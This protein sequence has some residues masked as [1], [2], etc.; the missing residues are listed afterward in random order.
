M[1]EA[2]EP[3]AIVDLVDT[4]PVTGEHGGDVDLLAVHADASAGGDQDVAVL[5]GVLQLG[6][7]GVWP[8]RGAVELGGASHSKRLMWPFLIEFAEEGIEAVLLLQA[9]VAWR[10]RGL[11]L[12]REVHALVAAVLLR[13]AWLDALDLDGE[14]EPPERELGEVVEA[15]GAGEGQA[16]VASEGGRQAA[17]L[18]Q[19]DKGF[20]DRAFLGGIKRLAQEQEAGR[21][22]GHGQGVTVSAVAELEL[23]LEVGTPQIV[24]PG[25]LRQGRALGLVAS[26]AGALDQ[27]VA[28]E[29][30]MDRAPGGDADIAGE[31]ATPFSSNNS[32]SWEKNAAEAFQ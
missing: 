18:E 28:V 19:P 20:D 22:V 30:R 9:V 23:A 10:S 14:P 1:H 3:N 29:H 21:L 7:A 6:Q 4:E 15:V 17:V 31:A 25:R 32:P 16:V 8:W 13:V 27:A 5:E 12:E 2:H 26:T 24:R 11:G